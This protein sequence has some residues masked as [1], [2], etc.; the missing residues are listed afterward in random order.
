MIAIV[1]LFVAIANCIHFSPL[2]GAETS[3]QSFEGYTRF[4]NKS[5]ATTSAKLTAYKNY[6]AS[7]HR[8]SEKNLKHGETTIHGLTKFADMSPKEFKDTILMKTLHENYMGPNAGNKRDEAQSNPTTPLDWV[9]KGKTTPVKNQLQCGSCWTFSATE[10]IESAN[11]IAGKITTSTWLAPQQ[12][13]DCDQNGDGC[14]G[15]WPSQ[16]MQFIISQGG[17]DTESSYPYTATDGTCKEAQGTIGATIKSVIPVSQ[18]ENQMY[19]ALRRSPLSICADA[20]SWQDYSGGIFTASQCTTN[21]DHAI[22]LTG[23]NPSQGGYWVVRNSW[24][25]DWGLDGFIWL[26]YGQDTCGITSY[27]AYAIA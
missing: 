9:A 4:F 8:V 27:V 3:R 18:N 23:Y 19:A 7:V 13:V 26:Q 17:Q 12:I 25:A 20:S 14:G 21:I 15:G 1:I 6:I 11:L 5:Y 22:Q 24:G 16:A 10:T 2:L